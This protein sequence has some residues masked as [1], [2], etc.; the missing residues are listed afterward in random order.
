MQENIDLE[1]IINQSISLP[2][3]V[4]KWMIGNKE[5]ITQYYSEKE[6]SMIWEFVPGPESM[7]PPGLCHGGMLASIMDE[8]MGSFV[9]LNGHIVFTVNLQINYRSPAPLN[10]TYFAIS[11]LVRLESKRIYAECRI[12]DIDNYLFASSSGLYI[13]TSWDKMLNPPEKYEKFKILK[14]LLDEGMP[15]SEVLRKIKYSNT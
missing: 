3:Y 15:L 5:S 13:K 4:S 11:K 1:S 2:S 10:R 9:F 12:T 14:K 6:H 7:G 8:G